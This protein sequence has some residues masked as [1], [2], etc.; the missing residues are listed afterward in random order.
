M[1]DEEKYLRLNVPEP[2][3]IGFE[4]STEEEKKKREKEFLEFIREVEKHPSK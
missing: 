4:E 3:V 2:K 1:T